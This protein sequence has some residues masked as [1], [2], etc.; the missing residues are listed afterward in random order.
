MIL[1]IRIEFGM[2]LLA[3]LAFPCLCPRSP[4]PR[5]R[6]TRTPR[7]CSSSRAGPTGQ[8]P[9]R[10]A[11]SRGPP[12]SSG[13]PIRPAC[14]SSSLYPPPTGTFTYINPKDPKTGKSRAYTLAEI[15]DVINDLLQTQH[16]HT[17]IR[18][19]STLTM[20]P[21]DAELKGSWFRRITQ[22]ELQEC[23]RTEI[24]EIVVL[25]GGGHNAEE[26][27][28]EVKRMLGD[29]A[30]VVPLPVTNQLII[31]ARRGRSCAFNLPNILPTDTGKARTFC[32][33]KCVF[34]RASAA[35]GVITKA[36][37]ARPTQ[38]VKMN[39]VSA[40]PTRDFSVR[41]HTVASDDATN[42]IFIT[43]AADKIDLAK[44]ILA[45]IDTPRFKADKG[46]LDGPPTFKNHA[47]SRRGMP[48]P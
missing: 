26:F 36:A 17:L 5:R 8:S 34:I 44:T 32:I 27:A 1:R 13:S 11:A 15:F 18:L 21:A 31:R 42:T 39:A 2:I 6:E 37:R 40:G 45:K 48:T 25:L 23:A 24:V 10:C 43:G 38:V 47:K 16:K 4:V 29:F 12:S 46:L 30:R 7:K 20:I 33:Y 28:P 19:D 35:E 41:P 14:R 9:S 22:E 3:G